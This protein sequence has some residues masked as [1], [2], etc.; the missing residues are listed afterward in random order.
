MTG[1]NDSWKYL[2]AWEF[3]VQPGRETKF[4]EA[5]GSNGEW[6]RLFRH[7]AGFVRTELTRK[8]D[9]PRR[10]VTLDFWLSKAAYDEFRRQQEIEYA[11]LD[12]LCE[13]LTERELELGRLQRV[14]D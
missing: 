14:G 6:V 12:K 3:D 11:A 10:Y 8:P 5:Y 7:G 13:K 4:E 1:E 9:D 2:V